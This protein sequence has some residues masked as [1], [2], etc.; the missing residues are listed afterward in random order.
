[1][2]MAGSG[3]G[4]NEL[5]KENASSDD[6]IPDDFF[7]ELAN[8]Q[9]IEDLVEN[10]QDGGTDMFDSESNHNESRENSPRMARCLA[11]IDVLTK[12]IERRKKKLEKELSQKGFSE[13]ELRKQLDRDIDDDDR[14]PHRSR[15]TRDRRLS[16]TPTRSRTRSR[17]PPYRH[18]ERGHIHRRPHPR[19]HSKSPNHWRHNRRSKSGSP[20]GKRRSSSTHKH[21]TFLEELAK[22]FA[23]QG[24]PITEKDYLSNAK[25]GALVEQRP[26]IAPMMNIVDANLM[27]PQINMPSFQSTSMPAHLNS[28]AF[29]TVGYPSNIYYGMDGL[30]PGIPMLPSAHMIGNVAEVCSTC[31][32]RDVP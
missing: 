2:S 7:D 8:A 17:S 26:S 12:D 22:T 21:L 6:D 1:M 24:K 11:E 27:L 31:S 15:R 32:L 9:F 28:V 5:G 10:A 14:R 23:E 16:R 20:N 30:P 29:P 13:Q 18:R 19:Q 25:G 4:D 3:I